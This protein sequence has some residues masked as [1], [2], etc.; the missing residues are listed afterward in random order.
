MLVQS[1]GDK[2]LPEY[3]ACKAISKDRV[4]KTRQVTGLFPVPIRMT[5]S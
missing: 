5:V 3:M 4:I 1:K 2:D